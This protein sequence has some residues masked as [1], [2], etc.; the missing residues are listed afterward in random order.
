MRTSMTTECQ[1]SERVENIGKVL[2]SVIQEEDNEI[3]EKD[4][5]SLVEKTTRE[6]SVGVSF[7]CRSSQKISEAT[8]RRNN[9]DILHFSRR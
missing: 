7:D 6:R 1:L 2:T 4:R 3:E 5:V 8:A 9:T